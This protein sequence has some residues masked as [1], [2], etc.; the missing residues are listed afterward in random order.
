[1]P[2]A[3]R[4]IVTV[5]MSVFSRRWNRRTKPPLSASER[6]ERSISLIRSSTTR[7]IPAQQYTLGRATSVVSGVF[8]VIDEKIIA[9]LGVRGKRRVALARAWLALADRRLMRAKLCLTVD[10]DSIE[11]RIWCVGAKRNI[12]QAIAILD[13]L[14]SVRVH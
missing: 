11:A 2:A 5:L 6:L 3:L 9:E 10:K 7:D 4:M 12:E 8:A 1:M 14:A 13:Q